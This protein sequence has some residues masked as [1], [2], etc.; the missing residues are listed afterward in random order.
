[1]SYPDGDAALK[2]NL[3][4]GY[5]S[6]YGWVNVDADPAV[7]PDVLAHLDDESAWA[8]RF[9]AGTVSRIEA[10]HVLEHL[11]HW[12]AVKLM[13]ACYVLLEPGGKLLV[14]TPDLDAVCRLPDGP[15]RTGLLY[16]GQEQPQGT[17]DDDRRARNPQFFC[18]RFGYTAKS[19]RV[20]LARVGLMVESVRSDDAVLTA[21]AVKPH[22]EKAAC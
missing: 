22:K 19:L 12:A 6:R 9:K 15:R 8:E 11:H 7:S 20:E 2:L 1:M 4:C 21:V 5:D 17:R 18:H 10:A 3:G 14:R 16:G 13:Q